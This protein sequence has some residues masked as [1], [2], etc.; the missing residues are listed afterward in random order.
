MMSHVDVESLADVLFHPLQVM[1]VLLQGLDALSKQLS[2]MSGSYYWRDSWGSRENLVRHVDKVATGTTMG[3][4]KQK[5]NPL[6]W[7]GAFGLRNPCSEWFVF[8]LCWH[9]QQGHRLL[10]AAL[11]VS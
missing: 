4:S 11:S 3:S 9:V 7:P 10:L 5:F 1:P 6:I 8:C 2:Q